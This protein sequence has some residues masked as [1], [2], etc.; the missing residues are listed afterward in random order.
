MTEQNKIIQTPPPEASARTAAAQA[1]IAKM[2]AIREEIPD[3][4][5]PRFQGSGRPLSNAAS[6]PA[7]FVERTAVAVANQ[8]LLVRPDALEPAVSRDLMAFAEAYAPLADEMEVVLKFLRHTIISARNIAGEDAL[9]TYT[10]AQRLAKRAATKAVLAPHVAD[11]R[12]EL[13]RHRKGKQVTEPTPPP[14]SSP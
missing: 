5:A 12:R 8:P 6:V 1:L 13:G 3:F 2:R 7:A 4:T 11:M 14:A 10:L 9:V